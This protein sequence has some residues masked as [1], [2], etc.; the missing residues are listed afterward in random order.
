MP[1]QL[2]ASEVNSKTDP[3]VSKQY[4]RTTPMHEQFNEFYTDVAGIKSCLLTTQRPNY[5]LVSRS[6][7]VAKRVGP[8]FLFLANA[9]SRKFEDI[10]KSK[11]VQ[12]TFQN[13]TGNQNWG[14]VSGTAT[15]AS[16]NDPR[17]GELWNKG[18]KAWFGDLGD[19]VH[20]G[21]AEDPRMALIEVKADYITYWKSTV[22]ALGFM[23]ETTIAP[24]TGEV[25]QTGVTREM[26][27]E[28]IEKARGMA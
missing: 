12:V 4:D 24:I 17:I 28:D 3:S 23:K 19:G 15:V 22:G 7:I 5:G 14:S 9:H 11:N 16:N 21:G 20:T 26:G 10:E 6:M 8:D 18:T 2:K 1:E 27:K 13:A 25:A